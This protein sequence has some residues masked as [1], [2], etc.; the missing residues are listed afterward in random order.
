MLHNMVF[1]CSLTFKGDYIMATDERRPVNRTGSSS[2]G[3]SA[4]S[5]G[6]KRTSDGRSQSSSRPRNMEDRPRRSSTQDHGDRPRR[7]PDREYDD[8]PRRNPD[9]DYEDRP[10]RTSDRDRDD[11]PARS[12]ERASE[13]RPRKSAPSN[14]KRPPEKKK[15]GVGK[16]ILIGVELLVL[17]VAAVVLWKFVMPATETGKMELS[18]DD[19]V[20]NE[21][22]KA[23]ME[24]TSSSQG[25]DGSSQDGGSSSGNSLYAGYRNV[26]LFGVDSREGALTKNT[27]SDTIIIAS[28]N[29]KTGD[30]KL[31]SVY[32]D[33]YLNLSNDSYNKCNAAYAKG[34]PMQ[35]INMLNMN[36]DM[37]IQ[38]FVTIGFDGLIDVIDALGGVEI[39]VLDSEII[40]L[41]NYQISMVGKSSDGETFTATAGTDYTPVTSAGR[42]TLNGLQATAYCR[43]RYVGNDFM[44]AER[45]RAVIQAILAKAKA[46]PTKLPGI[47][48]SLFSE[49]YTSLDLS[50]IVELLGNV[51]N[52]QIIDEGG[53]PEESMRGGATV[54]KK[55]SCVIPVDL[56]SNVKWL[57]G[58]LFDD[59]EY[60]PSSAV[61][62]YSE[63][64]TADTKPYM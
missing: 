3:S 18:V 13:D 19:I 56:Y 54:G 27:R 9:R 59:N 12:R 53:F 61:S 38:D 58:F 31:V 5:G 14:K 4:S 52:Y 41:N 42:Q 21:E 51:A 55:G 23:K 43:I 49:V 48:E 64:I 62:K 11:R 28:I 39:N 57:H 20:I 46:N 30:V 35:A 60:E 50:E 63:Q 7:N 2:K 17:I 33:T 25:G 32:R 16:Y 10:K 37:D 40:H 26:A 6:A 1:L 24:T 22:V 29:E 44:R 34:G 8:R 47:A 45:Q 36:L 15:S